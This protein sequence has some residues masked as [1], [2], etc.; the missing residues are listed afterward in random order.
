MKE[1]GDESAREKSIRH[2]HISTL[3]TW[4]A[5]RPLAASRATNFASL[6]SASGNPERR[7]KT[8]DLIV[9]LG[10]WENSLNQT[11]LAEARKAISEANGGM[12][13]KVLDPFAGGGSIPLE[14]L[15]LGC[16]TYAS[17][18]NPVAAL[19]LRCTLEYPQKFGHRVSKT[20]KG[21]ISEQ[22]ANSLLSDVNK[23]GSWILEDTRKELE[24][25]YPRER[26][27]SIPVGYV[28]V[29]T[30]PCQNPS[31]HA[32]IPLL[33]Q[34]W[35]ANNS[36]RKISLYPHVSGKLVEF[37][38]IGTG[39]SN[40][41]ANF[42]PEHGTVSKAVVT[43][44][45]CNSRIDGDTTRKL[46]EKR[47][48]D[49]RMV[50][51]I[52]ASEGAGRKFR[53][54][55]DEDNRVFEKA[56][57]FLSEKCKLLEKEWGVDPIPD[58]ATPE[59]KGRGAERAFSIRNYNMNT[60]GDLFNYRQKL[61]LIC[62]AERVRRAHSHMLEQRYDAEYALAI[63]TYLAVILDRLAD[64]N[65]TL[66]LYNSIRETVE[67]VFGRQT[68]GMI[69]DYVE[70]NP[71]TDVGWLNMQKWV[72]EVID[73]CSNIFP[74]ELQPIVPR[75]NQASATSLSFPD[76]FF[77]AVFTDPP[78]YD[79]VPY[80]YLSDFFYV[81]LKRTIGHLYPDYFATPLA[82]KRQE[83]VVYSNI[84]GGFEEGKKFFDQM[85][86]IS[87]A[88]INRVLKPKGISVI[89]Y[90]HKSTAGWETLVN[91]LLRSG[92]VVTG[93]WPI[94][95]ER[96]G[97]LRS[98]KSAALASSIYM[99]ARKLSKEQVGFYKEVKDALQR[100]LNEKL[101]RLWNEGI[102]GAD[103]FIAAIGSAI[104]VFG[105]YE[106]IID[107][108]GNAI[109]VTRLL[110]DVRRIVT[111]YAVKQVLHDGIVGEISPLTR[112]YVLWRWAYGEASMEYDDAGK[113]AQGIG[114]DL[115]REWNKGFIL[116]DKEFVC[117]LGPEDRET[118]ELGQSKELIDVLH[119]VLIL[120]KNG[121]NEDV[122]SV[123]KEAGFGRGDHFYKVAD[124]I[125]HSLPDSSKE[126]KL[127]EGFLQG[128]NRISE[129]LRRQAEQ[130]KLFE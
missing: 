129:D 91:S 98:M 3:H 41:P 75:V 4:W 130:T 94:H 60:W 97:R 103:F 36:R 83:I 25:F 71:F 92:L 101:D 31:C 86:G 20:A 11:L 126:K 17:D 99:V 29:R 24:R 5:R 38:I 107:D 121:K 73:H 48:S 70:V 46:F 23:W 88:E 81:W 119:R 6:I 12:V 26:D 52:L 69:W 72:G 123:L 114:I 80:S 34:F 116:K 90:A 50:A 27:G 111:D 8:K 124:A 28:W 78:Y 39:Y 64:K 108:A 54:A 42:D 61:A 117:V 51:V 79:N 40:K 66:V 47:E 10:K 35:L 68:L 118:E 84:E 44:L 96:P 63:A 65:S 32:Q 67:H 15:R 120:W 77:D 56:H 125:L 100:H 105:K 112:F 55:S 115:A 76:E 62:F 37:R 87:F 33:R 13:P 9:E 19:I 82:P 106:R 128:R 53:I 110:E 43:C 104:E 58:E 93:A 18:Y 74:P 22:K 89:V 122:L 109:E 1:I 127:L 45:I 49:E 57:G 30:I 16:E 59:G 102:S 7:Q 14:A 113:L 21:L 85:L 95:T 2:G